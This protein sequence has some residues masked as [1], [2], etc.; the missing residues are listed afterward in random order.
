MFLYITPI[1]KMCFKVFGYVKVY[2][3]SIVI[4]SS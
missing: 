3:N 2:V 1:N 4:I